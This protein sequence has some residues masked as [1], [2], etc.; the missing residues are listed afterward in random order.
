VWVQTVGVWPSERIQVF[1]NRFEG[2][3][4]GTARKLERPDRANDI[5]MARR[6]DVAFASNGDA[7]A[8]WE[9]GSGY[10]SS[11]EFSNGAWQ[12]ELDIGLG[13]PGLSRN[14]QIVFDSADVGIAIFSQASGITGTPTVFVS[15]FE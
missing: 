7:I 12:T 6:P 8:V 3:S 13:W 14:P 11:A 4:W 1:A 10:I 2:G 15:R 9:S 5:F